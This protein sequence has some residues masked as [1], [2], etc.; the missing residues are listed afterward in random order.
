MNANGRSA[1]APGRLAIRCASVRVAVGGDERRDPLHLLVRHG[2]IPRSDLLD[3]G[4]L[5]PAEVDELEQPV[6]GVADLGRRQPARPG[7][8][9]ARVGRPHAGH[10]LGV[11]AVRAALEE[12]ERAVREAADIVQRRLRQRLEW[13]QRRCERR[14]RRRGVRGEQRQLARL[15]LQHGLVRDR[16]RLGRPGVEPHEEPRAVALQLDRRLSRS[17]ELGRAVEAA[18]H[19]A[20]RRLLVRLPVAVDRARHDQAVD[21]PRHRDVV[22]AQPLG[23]VLR[24]PGLRDGVVAERRVALAGRRIRDPEAEAPVGEAE[25][26]VGGRRVAV[27]ARVGDD[28]DLE[29]EPLGGVDRQQADGVPTLLLGDGVPLDGAHRLLLADEAD[30]ALDVG[31]AQLL[32]GTGEPRELAQVRVATAPVPLRE[33]GEVVVVVG[34]DPLAQALEREARGR[35]RQPVVA[36]PERAQEPR[37]ALVEIRRKRALDPGEDRPLR[38]GAPDQQ[39]RVVRDADERRREHRDER[40]V[41]VAV[42]QQP[43]VREQVDDLLLAEVAAP[44]RAVRRQAGRAQLLLVPLRVRAGREEQDDLAGRGRAGVDELLHAPRDVPRLGAPPVEAAARST[45]T[46][47]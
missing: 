26:L 42:L 10:P 5:R 27:A 24:T 46:C 3:L 2:G 14:E 40:L 18:E 11:I 4:R 41:V 22:E 44:G 20:D 13:S 12:R 38:G 43:E 17:L 16:H 15:G 9:S 39:Q 47:R 31:P 33:H 29:L 32:V 19:P 8:G 1:R 28:D 23:L 34:D 30:E 35:L 36:L 7:D 37:V 45:Q 25:D 6:H 21:R